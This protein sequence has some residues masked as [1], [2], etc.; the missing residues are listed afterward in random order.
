MALISTRPAKVHQSHPSPSLQL[1]ACRTARS[2]RHPALPSAAPLFTSLTFESQLAAFHDTGLTCPA[3]RR[4]PDAARIKAEGAG[5]PEAAWP[6]VAGPAAA[7]S[8]QGGCEPPARGAPAPLAG[9]LGPQGDCFGT[10]P[11]PNGDLRGV[12]RAADLAALV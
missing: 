8:H 2:L 11:G 12:G 6:E 1:Q 5:R 3:R 7:C 10:R 9:R 4:V